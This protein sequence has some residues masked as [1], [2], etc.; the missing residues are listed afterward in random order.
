[1]FSNVAAARH[2]QSLFVTQYTAVAMNKNYHPDN[3]HSTTFFFNDESSA[4]VSKT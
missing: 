1:M 4:S 2:A 3:F